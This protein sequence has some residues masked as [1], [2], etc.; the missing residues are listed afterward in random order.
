MSDPD[1]WWLNLTNLA[2]GTGVLLCVLAVA[3]SAVWCAIQN[4]SK[5]HRV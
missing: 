2:L 4:R 3:A 1:T 5:T